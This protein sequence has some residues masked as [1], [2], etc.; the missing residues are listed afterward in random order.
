M[1]SIYFFVKAFSFILALCKDKHNK[2]FYI[3]ICWKKLFFFRK[4]ELRALILRNTIFQ[5]FE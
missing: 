2:S 5:H 4:F 1:F 3:Y